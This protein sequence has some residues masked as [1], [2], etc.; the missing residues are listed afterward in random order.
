MQFKKHGEVDYHTGQLSQVLPMNCCFLPNAKTPTRPMP[1]DHWGWRILET[2]LD[3]RP[4]L[5]R[6]VLFAPNYPHSPVERQVRI[7]W[8]L[9][10]FFP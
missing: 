6:N 9:G 4:E 10:F 3:D 5:R 1:L 8:G 7:V 2:K